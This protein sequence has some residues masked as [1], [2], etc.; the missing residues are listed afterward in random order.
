MSVRAECCANGADEVFKA[1][2]NDRF[3]VDSDADLIEL[4]GQIE[5]V[6]VLPLRREHLG[7]DGDDFRFHEAA[8]SS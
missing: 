1:I 4:F 3:E 5:G 8:F 7:A 2:A 6:G